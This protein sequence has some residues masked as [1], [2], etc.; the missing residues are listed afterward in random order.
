MMGQ[1][2]IFLWAGASLWG[3]VLGFCYFGGLL[4]TTQ[5]LPL[6]KNPK[7]WLILSFSLRM[8]IALAGFWFILEKDLISFFFTLGTFFFIRF[9]FIRNSCFMLRGD[10]HAH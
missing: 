4:W 2:D 7:R 6:R 8:V 1:T 9:L 5:L 3:L 10:N